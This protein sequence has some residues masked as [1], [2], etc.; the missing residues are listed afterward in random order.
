MTQDAH[1]TQLQ[2]K[3]QSLENTIHQA[4]I[5]RM[6]DEKV[7]DLKKSKLKLKEEIVHLENATH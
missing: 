7:Q 3:H 5:H 2:D 6:P 1:V 4:Y